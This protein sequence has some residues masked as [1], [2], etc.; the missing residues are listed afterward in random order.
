MKVQEAVA[1]VTE[2][3]A[4]YDKALT[5]RIGIEGPRSYDVSE[6]LKAANTLATKITDGRA[7]GADDDIPF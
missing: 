3:V 4:A 1:L 7:T 5:P 6:I 2:L